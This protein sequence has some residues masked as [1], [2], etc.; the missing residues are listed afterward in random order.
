VIGANDES[1]LQT[2]VTGEGTIKFYYK[3]ASGTND[4]FRFKVDGVTKFYKS[5]LLE[6]TRDSHLFLSGHIAISLFF[7]SYAKIRQNRR[8]GFC[9]PYHSAGEQPPGGVLRG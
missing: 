3:K 7:W 9:S 5:K 6:T 4:T 2:T 8:R 1:W